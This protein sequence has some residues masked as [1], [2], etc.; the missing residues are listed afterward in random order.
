MNTGKVRIYELSKELDLENKDILAICKDEGIAAKSHSS[1]ITEEDVA[2]IRSVAT[3]E[4]YKPISKKATR[5]K[6]SSTSKSSSSATKPLAKPNRPR[7]Q[8]ILEIRRYPKPANEPAT[9]PSRPE[10]SSEPAATP[11]SSAAIGG[12]KPTP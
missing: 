5:P 9:P 8:Q 2:K 1:T 3:A 10:S 11:T 7:Q 4:G 6:A 12:K